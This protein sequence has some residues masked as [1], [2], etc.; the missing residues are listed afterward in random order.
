MKIID[1][2]MH[3][4]DVQAFYTAADNAGVDYSYEGYMK[5][6]AAAGIVASICM[7]LAESTPHSFPDHN[8]EVPMTAN[9]TKEPPPKLYTCLGVNPHRLDDD[10]IARIRQAIKAD[11]GI[12]GFKIYAGYYH[13]YIHDPIYAPIYKLAA[14]HGLTVAI[15]TGDTYSEKGLL[16]YSHPLAA[17]RLAVEYRDTQ[18][19]LCH[20]GNPWVVDACAVAYKNRNVF[21]DISGLEEGNAAKIKETE[22]N[23][24]VIQHV[25]TGLA[26]LDDYTKV[27]FGTDWPIVPLEAYIDFCKK[28]IP[29]HTHNEVFAGNAQRVYKMA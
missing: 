11:K 12:V 19:L 18:F 16:E 9:L 1:A 27:L 28:L 23:Q 14:E 20:M 25:K 26:H 4:S 15:H 24:L 7:G 13:Y 5:E 10:A 21:L 3:F 29:R 22:N 2:H 8:A 17:D 6:R